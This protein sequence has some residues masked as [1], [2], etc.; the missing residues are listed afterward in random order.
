MLSAQQTFRRITPLLIHTMGTGWAEATA[1]PAIEGWDALSSWPVSLFY[2]NNI[3]QFIRRYLWDRL[4]HFCFDSFEMYQNNFPFDE[5]FFTTSE[6]K[7][8]LMTPMI[9]SSS[10]GGLEAEALKPEL[11]SESPGELVKTQT[12]G[13]LLQ[14]FQVSRSR[15]EPENLHF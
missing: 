8:L 15:M 7:S 13:P 14:G 12:A 2:I 1:S 3:N 4:W 5:V 9:L 11:M 10:C 6:L